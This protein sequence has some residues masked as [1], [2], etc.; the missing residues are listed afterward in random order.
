[1]TAATAPASVPMTVVA[2]DARRDFGLG[3]GFFRAERAAADR[4]AADRV[5]FFCLAIFVGLAARV[6]P[7]RVFGAAF[8][9]ERLAARLAG[10]F[11]FVVDARLAADRLAAAD[12]VAAARLPLAPLRDALFATLAS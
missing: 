7:R 8:F 3:A 4:A 10:R 5:A 9:V 1:M 6:V 12:R 2:V 11:F